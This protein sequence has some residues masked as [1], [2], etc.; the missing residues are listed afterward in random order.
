MRMLARAGRIEAFH[1][2]HAHRISIE[3]YVID[4]A[5][6]PDR[7]WIIELNPYSPT[8]GACLFDWGAD[9]AT[10]A[11]APVEIRVLQASGTHPRH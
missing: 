6:L 3:S 8:T 2:V 7:V 11:A 5:V 4:L 1:A 9:A 10:L